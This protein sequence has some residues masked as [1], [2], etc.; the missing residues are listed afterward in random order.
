MAVQVGL[1]NNLEYYL[2]KTS[3][4][5]SLPTEVLP[6]DVCQTCCCVTHLVPL[7]TIHHSCADPCRLFTSGGKSQHFYAVRLPL[8]GS[9]PWPYPCVPGAS[10]PRVTAQL[11][12]CSALDTCVYFSLVDLYHEETQKGTGSHHLCCLRSVTVSVICEDRHL[13]LNIYRACVPVGDA[14]SAL[15]PAGPGD[16]PLRHSQQYMVFLNVQ[17]APCVLMRRR[18][19]NGQI[20]G[21]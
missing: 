3:K 13:Y 12:E 14:H 5:S 6:A 9:S 21:W 1:E 20:T 11:E 4:S 7:F 8:A 2:Q 17:H 18:R 10:R 19:W 15:L 16:T